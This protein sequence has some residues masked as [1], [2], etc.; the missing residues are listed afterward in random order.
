MLLRAGLASRRTT[1]AVV[2][3]YAAILAATGAAWGGAFYLFGDHPALLGMALLTFLLGVRHAVDPDHIAAIDSVTRNLVQAGKQPISVGL[4]FALGHSSVV[5][6]GS[7]AVAYTA[8]NLAETFQQFEAVGEVIGGGISALVLL[9]LGVMNLM[10]LRQVL[11]SRRSSAP[12]D[13]PASLDHE[14]KSG[15]GIPR[16]LRP[17]TR[18]IVQPWQMLFLGFLFALG[19]E[20]ASAVSLFGVAASQALEGSPI[21]SVLVLSALFTA[22]MVFVDT[23]DGILML[24]VYKWAHKD[25]GRTYRYNMMVTGLSASIALLIGVAGITN[26]VSSSIGTAIPEWLS[27]DRLEAHVGSLGLLVVCIFTSIWLIAR[28]F[29]HFPLRSNS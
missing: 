2:A 6:C 21:A 8:A 11:A 28:V 25:P 15:F 9:L 23:T 1:P 12:Y 14:A 20:T 13:R 10:V 4:W 26:V 19:F 16:F 3:L 18:L 7:V 17:L 24:H 29:T 27:L 22:G 5:V